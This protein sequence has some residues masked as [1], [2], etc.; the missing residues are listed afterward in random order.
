MNKTTESSKIF[1]GLE[2]N[3]QILNV[4]STLKIKLREVL[5]FASEMR[6]IRFKKILLHNAI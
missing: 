5:H 2:A 1:T 6:A 3:V 4:L